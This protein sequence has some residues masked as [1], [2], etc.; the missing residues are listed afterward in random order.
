MF[1]NLYFI[2]TKIHSAWAL[3]ASEGIIVIDTLFDYAIEPEIVEGL[4]KLGLEP[5][6]IKYVLISHAHGDHD[7]GAARLQSR[8]GAKVVM[9]TAD[10]EATLQRPATAAGGVPNRDVSVGPEGSAIKLGDTTVKISRNARPY[11]GHAVVP[12]PSQGRN[13]DADCGLLGRHR[14]QLPAAAQRTSPSTAT[15]RKRWRKPRAR[16]A[17]PS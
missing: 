15:A 16:P 13:P 5:R 12:I 7:Q 9:G 4:T 10:W 2:G 1:D 17:R 6:N 8:Y 11:T 14:F 3:T